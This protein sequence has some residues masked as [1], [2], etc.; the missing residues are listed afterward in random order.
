MT[1]R[2]AI[3]ISLLLA[4]LIAS[5]CGGG[6]D[7]TS[8]STV[9]K[10]VLIKK[11]DAICKKSE[12]QFQAQVLGY[13]K[14]LKGKSATKA[15]ERQIVA[16]YQLP[17]LQDQVKELE[18][19]GAPDGED[20]QVEAIL[21]GMRAVL[22]EGRNDPRANLAASSAPLAESADQARKYGFKVCLAQY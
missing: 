1:W 20:E 19:L 16:D 5:G 7:D 14:L 6:G 9:T 12:E 15:Q 4:I 3:P 17:G 13:F 2:T 22:A 11:G 10:T 18:K 21:D 8:T